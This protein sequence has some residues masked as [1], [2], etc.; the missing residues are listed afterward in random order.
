MTSQ[1]MPPQIPTGMKTYVCTHVFDGSRPV[2][3]V[4]RPEGDWCALCGDQH[5]DDASAYRVVG[6]GHVL[7]YDPS[8]AEVFDLLRNQEAE[9][10]AVGEPWV[11]TNF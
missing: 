4:T 11:R 8:V 6:M 3:Y 5:P 7:N 2:L 9:R 10:E 1:T